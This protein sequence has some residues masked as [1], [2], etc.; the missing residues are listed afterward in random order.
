MGSKEEVPGFKDLETEVADNVDMAKNH[1]MMHNDMDREVVRKIPEVHRDTNSKVAAE[2]TG[3]SCH[4]SIYSASKTKMMCFNQNGISVEV[5]ES[6][7]H[8]H[9][10]ETTVQQSSNEEEPLGFGRGTKLQSIDVAQINTSKQTKVEEALKDTHCEDGV[11]PLGLESHS[12]LK[13]GVN[14]VLVCHPPQCIE[15]PSKGLVT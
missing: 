12:M 6:Y 11:A 1:L 13:R 14:L 5:L 4:E 10:L 8:V 9:P 3:S 7:Q 2:G 15:Q